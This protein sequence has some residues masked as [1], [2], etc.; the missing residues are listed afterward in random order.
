MRIGSLA[1]TEVLTAPDWVP[2]L[3]VY[4]VPMTALGGTIGIGFIGRVL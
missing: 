1:D 4:Q 3:C 2:K